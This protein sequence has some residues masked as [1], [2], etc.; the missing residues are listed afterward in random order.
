MA[1]ASALAGCSWRPWT[2]DDCA[3]DAAA[4]AWDGVKSAA[5]AAGG[6]VG[7]FAGWVAEGVVYIGGS[8]FMLA[9]QAIDRGLAAVGIDTDLGEAVTSAVRRL[10]SR[11]GS[12][13]G[14]VVGA[15]L[16]DPKTFLVVV[17][18]AL[19]C[20]ATAL[21][22]VVAAP[23]CA[24]TL[25]QAT[26][27]IVTATIAETVENLVAPLIGEERARILGGLIAKYKDALASGTIPE[28][29]SIDDLERA[30]DDLARRA[31]QA[32]THALDS[33]LSTYAGASARAGLD[34]LAQLDPRQLAE[35]VPQPAAAIDYAAQRLRTTPAAI[36]AA[37]AGAALA[38]RSATQRAQRA[39][40]RGVDAGAALAEMR[41]GID[42]AVRSAAADL[43]AAAEA[44]VLEVP[45]VADLAA[46]LGRLG[47]RVNSPQLRDSTRARIARAIADHPGMPLDE[48]L[49]S[50]PVWSVLDGARVRVGL[51]L[52]Q[53]VD[54]QAAQL[55]AQPALAL[56]RGA[57][58]ARRRAALLAAVD[59]SPRLPD[60][61]STAA[62][63]QLLAPLVADYMRGN[64]NPNIPGAAARFD[65]TQLDRGFAL[66][67]LRGASFADRVAAAQAKQQKK[68]PAWVLPAAAAAVV[69]FFVLGRR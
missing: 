69:A 23:A 47:V 39:L 9:A 11:V 2:W 46:D 4:A 17:G 12:F 68:L 22:A 33:A 36:D 49:D 55:Y 42:A 32:G 1:P 38:V 26:Q 6:A 29:P 19:S 24:A 52:A 67:P 37:Q 65:A 44:T 43:A 45:E 28:M 56:Y 31:I 3:E 21:G 15:V 64:M 60:T 66:D 62:R 5:A 57:S 10:A 13:V 41:N 18:A 50:L 27:R 35:A 7:E 8:A 61:L 59:R 63:A 51:T 54:V 40:A 30:A 25:E 16:S 58:T 14:S 48:L 53:V 20:G 34:Y